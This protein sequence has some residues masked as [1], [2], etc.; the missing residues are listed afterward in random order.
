MKNKNQPELPEN[1]TV[2]KSDNQGVKEDTFIQTGRHRQ[3]GGEDMEQGD[4]LGW[5][6]QWLADSVVPHL[7]VNKLGGTTGEQDRPCNPQFQP[8]EPL[9]IEPV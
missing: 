7:N 6:R 2:W 9:A 1:R 8:R 4:T 3:P 5:A